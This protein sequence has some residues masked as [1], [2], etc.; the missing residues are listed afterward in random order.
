MGNVGVHEGGGRHTEGRRG[1]T[2]IC[3]RI[4]CVCRGGVVKKS[5]PGKAGCLNAF[6]ISISFSTKNPFS[7][8]YP[9]DNVEASN[10]ATTPVLLQ[11]RSSAT[12]GY[13]K[14]TPYGTSAQTPRTVHAARWTPTSSSIYRVRAILTVLF[15]GLSCTFALSSRCLG[16]AC[17]YCNPQPCTGGSVISAD[18]L[19]RLTPLSLSLLSLAWEQDRRCQPSCFIALVAAPETSG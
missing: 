8:L 7:G 15:V 2:Y 6:E 11:E 9:D 18:P 19:R 13:S 1:C 4:S 14:S 12:A 10:S 17:P 3:V 5:F 16:K